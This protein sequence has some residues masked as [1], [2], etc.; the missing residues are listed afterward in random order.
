MHKAITCS[1]LIIFLLSSIIFTLNFVQAA[2]TN[3]PS[4]ISSDTILTK[5]GSPYS[6]LGPTRINAGVTLTIQ[7]GATI[8]LGSN[9]IQ[10]DG[11]LNARGT[12]TD[13]IYIL[14]APVNA[15]EIKFTNSSTSW[16]EQLG[17]G[18]IIENA[19]LNQTVISVINCSVKINRDTFN[20][21]ADMQH[22][23]VAI[24]TNGGTSTISNNNFNLCG[25]DI[26]DSSTISN[27]VIGGGMGLWGG[28]PIVTNNQISGGS[29]YFWIGRSFDRDYDA[30]AIM[31]CS[32][33]VSSNTINGV[34]GFNAFEH[35]DNEYNF[36][37][38]A[39]ITGNKI[40]LSN[41]YNVGIDIGAGTGTIDI[42]NNIISN[43]PTGINISNMTEILVKIQGNLITNSN[44]TAIFATGNATI[45][46]NTLSNN[47]IGII[48][49]NAVTPTISGNNIENSSQYSLKLMGTSSNIDASGNWWGTTDTQTI[50]QS[51][52][53]QKYDFNLGKVNITPI[54]TAPD[55]TAPEAQPVESSPT[56]NPTTTD[57]SPTPSIPE[58]STMAIIVLLVAATFA[59]TVGVRKLSGKVPIRQIP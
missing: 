36:Y 44:S 16:N 13:P 31:H 57:A 1:L 24:S 22:N 21:S 26:S 38:H 59:I 20:D 30:L 27:N 46:D 23:N 39:L 15:A 53:D 41:V 58:Y 42:I 56:S 35:E 48:L 34:I 51:I 8:S 49:S 45:Q 17:T 47:G 5:D 28:S 19:V 10:V 6:I 11:T 4:I 54:L 9:Y 14:G 52:Y 43:V 33:T 50:T 7:A 18:C 25:L 40:N 37:N 32:P 3:L 2:G 29:S 55:T 12:N